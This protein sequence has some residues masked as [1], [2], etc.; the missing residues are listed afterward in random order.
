MT[1]DAP[2]DYLVKMCLSSFSTVKSYFFPF[3]IMYSLKGSH[4]PTLKEWGVMPPFFQGG[5]SIYYYLY[6]PWHLLYLDPITK[7]C[8]L[9]FNSL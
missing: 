9:I 7:H 6:L 5:V 2:L 1:I 8:L 4:H 3:S